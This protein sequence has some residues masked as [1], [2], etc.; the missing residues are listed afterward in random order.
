MTGSATVAS[1]AG[2]MA[3]DF[4]AMIASLFMGYVIAFHW[5]MLMQGLTLV[6]SLLL[7]SH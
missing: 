5:L 4:H 1:E 6:S 7:V 3:A 2:Y